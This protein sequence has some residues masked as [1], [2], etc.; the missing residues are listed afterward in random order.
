[1]ALYKILPQQG[2]F[3][4]LKILRKLKESLSLSEA[5]VRRCIRR[6][7]R[8]NE[9]DLEVFDQKPPLCVKCNK[10]MEPTPTIQIDKKADPNKNV[11]LGSEAYLI[12]QNALRKLDKDEKLTE[13]HMSL[14]EKFIE[15]PE[16]KE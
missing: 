2:V 7:Y 12:C 4:T 10:H 11:H 13:D 8:C 6:K 15:K 1:M 5:E 3:V 16:N 9:C 14:Y